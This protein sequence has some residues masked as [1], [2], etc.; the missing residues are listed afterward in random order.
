MRTEMAIA[1][2]VENLAAI[3]AFVGDAC[4]RAGAGRDAASAV[5][6][7]V[8]EACSNIIEHAYAGSPGGTIAITCEADAEALRVTL[9][10]R[11]RAFAPETLPAAD[12]TSGW[13]QRRVGG[14]GWHLMRSSVDE[15]DYGPDPAGGNRLILLKRLGA[16]G[17]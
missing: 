16:G 4:R 14:L 12:T 13:R 2:R 9:V 5:A 17:A 7:A 3:R 6:L 1:A 10:D 11:G 15:V 8:D